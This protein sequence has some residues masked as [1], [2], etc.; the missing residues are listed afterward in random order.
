MTSASH[1][2]AERR[3]WLCAA[4]K[5]AKR[6]KSS[7]GRKN[8]S[9]TS[10]TSPA[11]SSWSPPAAV[12]GLRHPRPPTCS[13]TCPTRSPWLRAFAFLPGQGNPAGSRSPAPPLPCRPRPAPTAGG[14]RWRRTAASLPDRPGP[15]QKLP[16]AD[17]KER[18]S[19]ARPRSRPGQLLPR[20]TRRAPGTSTWGLR[21]Q[22]GAAPPARPRHFQPGLRGAGLGR[23]P[24]GH[25]GVL[26]APR[27]PQ[28]HALGGARGRADG[29]VRGVC[30]TG[31]CH[32]RTALP[33]C[34]SLQHHLCRT[35]LPRINHLLFRPT[36]R[37]RRAVTLSVTVNLP[38]C[39][40]LPRA[41]ER[42][43]KS[44]CKRLH[45]ALPGYLGGSP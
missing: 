7:S 10:R 23:D 26:G 4:E 37:H 5:T 12:P 40:G 22:R 6:R 19:P 44:D 35:R 11:S 8:K 43:D 38:A 3:V 24:V 42:G 34:P 13:A 30:P 9:R 15:A 25:R 32:L 20:Q 36:S 45:R 29:G 39:A 28:E 18:M 2:K 41:T 17:V 27:L 16:E 14:G 33:S 1:G 21:Q 31:C